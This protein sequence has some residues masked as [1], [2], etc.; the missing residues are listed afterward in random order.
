[1]FKCPF[2]SRKYSKKLALYE[3]MELEH[4]IDLQK[5]PA[6][7]VYFNFRNRY[8]LTKGNGKCVMTGKPTNF[9]LTTERY[10]RFADE[11][12]REKY[13]E[14]FKKNMKKVYGKTTL[15]DDPEHQKNMLAGRKISGE[16]IWADG[17][18]S[19]YTGSY[20]K[21]FLEYLE[22]QLMWN[23]PSDVMS[24]APMVFAYNY[25]DEVERFHIPDF[26]ITS[27]NLIVNV[28]AADNKH[29]RLRD[30]EIE[31][32][33]DEAIIKTGEYNYL[34]LY[35]NKFDRFIQV[36]DRIK[37]SKPSDKRVILEQTQ[38]G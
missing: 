12:A 17:T 10:E 32:L 34:K 27:L 38:L 7:Q 22:T 26:Y 4:K 1:M 14:Y 23:N 6:A 29:Y 30:I 28:K 31:K 2:C 19:R 18:K 37:E 21:N 11:K 25:L 5:L 35:D 33:Q 3:H 36:M 24:P 15:L 20:E 16:Y 13:R 8:A 9:N